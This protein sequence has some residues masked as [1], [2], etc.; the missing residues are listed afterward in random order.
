[1]EF[2]I[3]YVFIERTK[4]QAH[5]DFLDDHP[6]PDE[7]EISKDLLDEKSFVVDISWMMFLDRVDEKEEIGDGMI[8]FSL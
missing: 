3:V 2:E 1:M 5:A 7:Y 6:I 8:F 4:G